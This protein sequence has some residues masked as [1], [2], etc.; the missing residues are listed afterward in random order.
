MQIKKLNDRAKMPSFA[1]SAD[2]GMDLFTTER[3]VIAPGERKGA[4]TGLS[5]AIPDGHVGLIWEKSGLAFKGGIKTVGGVVDSG[6]RG[7][8]MVGLINTSDQEYIFE[9]GDKVA[10]MLIQRIHHPELEEVTEL[11]E[12]ERGTGGFGSTGKQ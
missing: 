5:M 9:V 10:Q 8:V 2:A 1:H 12:T 4:P 6:Y 7:E 3:I 11:S